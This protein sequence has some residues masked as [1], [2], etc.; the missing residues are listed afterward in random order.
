MKLR[1]WSQSEV[2]YG[3]KIFDSGVNGARSG[4][5]AFLQGDSVTP[6]ISAAVAKSWKH[7][8]FGAC[9]GLMLFPGNKRKSVGQ[10][11]AY[12]FLG[13][14]LGLGLGIAWASRRLT[15]SMANGAFDNIAR[16]RDEHWLES[17]PID[18]A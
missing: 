15:G 12:G 5:E 7:A 3:K 10:M 14:A 17:H 9:L 1:E 16:V 4:R 18:Y 6:F 11:F 8:A 13:G 2:E